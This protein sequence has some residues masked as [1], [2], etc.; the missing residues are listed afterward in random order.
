MPFR[1]TRRQGI[2]AAIALLLIPVVVVLGSRFWVVRS[3]A[4]HVVHQADRVPNA[5]V[6]LVLGAGVWRGNE[7]S[8]AMRERVE[9]AA[10]LY[11]H[12]TVTHLL[13]SGDNSRA[14]YD[15]PTVMRRVALAAGVPAKNVT[16]DF[17]GFDTWDSCSRAKRIFGVRSAVVVT[18]SF[19]I[20]RAVALCR[21]AGIAANGFGIPDLQGQK[22]ATLRLREW[23]AAPKAAWEMLIG[24]DPTKLGNPEPLDGSVHPANG[25]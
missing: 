14:G 17:A 20:D 5:P 15:E 4:N 19:H 16:L 2:V 18:H 22:G 21:S 13:L 6:A 3:A 10:Q 8:P 9:A 24:P 11:H 7:A 1:P 23:A 25:E 12:G